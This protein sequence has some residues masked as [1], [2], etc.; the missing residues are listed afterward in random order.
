MKILVIGD[1]GNM[2]Q[3]YVAILK[4]IGKHC[5]H[6][7]DVEVLGWDKKRTPRS[8]V[9]RAIAKCDRVIIATPTN[10]HIDMATRC[11]KLGKDFL[12]EKPLDK[13]PN[14][15]AELASLCRRNGVDGRMVCN[16]AFTRSVPQEIE[17]WKPHSARIDYHNFRSGNDGLEW[18]CIQ[19]IFLAKKGR[20]RLSLDLPWCDTSIN[21]AHI[22]AADIEQSYVSMIKTWFKKPTRLWG[23]KEAQEATQTVL[24]YVNLK[25]GGENENRRCC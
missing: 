21:G 19:L 14:R 20:C 4:W 15:I 3:R 10:T 25:K 12:C 8:T 11:A 1:M 23:L 6:D 24:E 22:N 5:Q 7:V 17:M 13:N 9:N 16:W 2:G 18:D